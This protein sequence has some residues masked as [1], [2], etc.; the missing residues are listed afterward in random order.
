MLHAKEYDMPRTHTRSFLV[1]HYE[2]DACGRVH[3]ANYLR[4]MQEAAFDASSAAGYDMARYEAM[5]N[6]WLIRE[7]EMEVLRPLHYDDSIQV[8]T[9]VADFRRVRSRRAYELSLADS[10]VLVARARTDWAFL[11]RATERPAPIPEEM[12]AA[13]FPE[14]LPEVA[15]PRERFPSAPPPPPGAF[16]TWRRVEWQDLDT[17]GHANNAVYLAYFEECARQA[18]ATYGWPVARMEAEGFFVQ[19]RHHQIEYRQP[20]LLDEELEITT[21]HSLAEPGSAIRHYT[22]TRVGDGALVSRARTLL[23]VADLATGKAIPIPDAY[24][25]DLAPNIAV[26]AI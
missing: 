3:H 25:G 6:F 17:A 7:T 15:P 12:I 20:A 5:G 10:G 4:Y 19:E 11:N 23:G 24:L 26:Q 2:C 13:F 22:L 9:W 1:R 18:A 21:W 14:G 16:R 8:R